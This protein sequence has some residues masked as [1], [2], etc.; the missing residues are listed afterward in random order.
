MAQRAVTTPL[1]D[2][3]V[4]AHSMVLQMHNGTLR[5]PGADF[6]LFNAGEAE[7]VALGEDHNMKEIPELIG[8]AHPGSYTLNPGVKY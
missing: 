2:S 8:G 1:F 6:V 4:A 3:V 7:F 5:G